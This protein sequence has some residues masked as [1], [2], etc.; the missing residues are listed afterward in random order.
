MQAI[1]VEGIRTPFGVNPPP[2]L[3]PSA[4]VVG[5]RLT[6]HN[7]PVPQEGVVGQQDVVRPPTGVRNPSGERRSNVGAMIVC[8]CIEMDE[9]AGAISLLLVIT[10]QKGRFTHL[11]AINEAGLP[12]DRSTTGRCR[13]Q[14]VIVRMKRPPCR[15][16]G[17][18]AALR[19]DGGRCRLS[20]SGLSCRSTIGTN[21]T[22][23][24]DPI[25]LH[26]PLSQSRPQEEPA[27]R[28]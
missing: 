7:D 19:G 18:R 28:K 9:D 27:G 3:P 12:Q 2:A 22:H 25:G 23:T 6:S 20:P 24:G 14:G 26:Q 17:K 11:D 8:Q 10:P 16:G 15:S 21:T 1:R 5:Q 13:G 4:G